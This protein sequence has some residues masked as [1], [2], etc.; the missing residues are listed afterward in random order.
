ML[1]SRET[2][3]PSRRGL[4]AAAG[5]GVAAA[6]FSSRVLA[7][8]PSVDGIKIGPENF[9]LTLD[10]TKGTVL[11]DLLPFKAAVSSVA[12][13]QRAAFAVALGR[14]VVDAVLQELENADAATLQELTVSFV[15]VTQRDEYNKP[16]AG[17]LQQVGSVKVALADGKIT[18]VANVGSYQF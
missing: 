6:A 1:Y 16:R 8:A 3:L 5:F 4:I 13:P 14:K 7:Q 12:E 18:D 10:T 11:V 17:G 2:A 15:Y 9:I